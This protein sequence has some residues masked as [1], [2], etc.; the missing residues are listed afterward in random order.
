MKHPSGGSRA[1]VRN[2]A[3]PRARG[4]FVHFLD[5]GDIVPVGHY[6]AA[7]SAFAEAPG[8]GVVFGWIEPFG[9]DQAALHH[10][11]EYF[12]K[13]RQRVAACQRFGPKWALAATLLFDTAP[14]VGSAAMIR[15]EC[16]LPIDGFDAEVALVEDI[17]F[18]GRAIRRFGASVIDRATLLRRTGPL[19]HRPG[20]G[21]VLATSYARMR[22]KYRT[23]WGAADYYALR[24]FART[25]LRVV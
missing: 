18:Y 5:D 1:R 24:G 10:E 15:R 12:E 7:A 3:W 17:D 13:A 19:V 21:P 14:L 8:A 2:A 22:A 6:D 16:I 25:V 20:F 11:R 9:T 4:R 23:E